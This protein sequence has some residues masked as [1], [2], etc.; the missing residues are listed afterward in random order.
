MSW[1][2]ERP[3]I[4]TPHAQEMARLVQEKPASDESG[5]VAQVERLVHLTQG[6][7]LLK[8]PHTLV[9]ACL[10][11]ELQIFQNTTGSVALAKAGSGD[12][13][14]GLIAGLWAQLGTAQV[15]SIF[16]A[17][18]AAV[19]GVYLHGLAGELAADTKTHYAVL[20]SD[21]LAAIPGALQQ[22]QGD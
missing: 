2:K 7:C 16:T 8:G 17:Y 22:V 13:L 15:F 9:G 12:V 11:T 4:F 6:V 19:C 20:A 18:Q 21:T 14:S 5:R 3:V 1:P 10:Q